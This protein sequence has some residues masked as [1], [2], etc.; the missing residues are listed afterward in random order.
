MDVT[1]SSVES[2]IVGLDLLL[3]GLDCLVD[4]IIYTSSSCRIIPT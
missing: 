3:S 4:S 2:G 1:G